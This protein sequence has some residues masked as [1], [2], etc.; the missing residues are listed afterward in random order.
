M[1]SLPLG[2][3]CSDGMQITDAARLNAVRHELALAAS[4]RDV[5]DSDERCAIVEVF[6]AP[7]PRA[8]SQRQEQS[9]RAIE[10]AESLLSE[11]YRDRLTPH[12]YS[13]ALRVSRMPVGDLRPEM[14]EAML[15]LYQRIVGTRA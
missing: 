7:P 2:D 4:P 3:P 13:R 10:A 5:T 8:V 6:D 12:A 11:D 15:R 1:L 14:A 9:I